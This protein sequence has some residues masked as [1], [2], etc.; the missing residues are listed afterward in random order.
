MKA[1]NQVT[2]TLDLNKCLFSQLPIAPT[3][4]E[5]AETQVKL[6]DK[7]NQEIGLCKT[8]FALFSIDGN[9]RQNKLSGVLDEFN[10]IKSLSD[11]KLEKD[12]NN[13]IT[14]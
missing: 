11:N 8:H 6:T 13:T 9:P 7:N 3:A 10:G 5:N 1:N 4:C 12:E 14:K 2:Q